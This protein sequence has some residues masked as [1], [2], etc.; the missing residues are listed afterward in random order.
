MDADAA[1]VAGYFDCIGIGE[2]V[3]SLLLAV[4][5]VPRGVSPIIRPNSDVPTELMQ[6]CALPQHVKH[7]LAYLRANVGEKVTL[8]DLATACSVPERTLLKQFKQFLGTSPLAHF[9]RIRLTT[10]RTELLRSDDTNSISEIASRCGFTHLGRFAADYRRTFGEKPSATRRRARQSSGTGAVTNHVSTLQYTSVDSRQRPSLVIQALRT[11]TLQE[12]RAAQELLEQ[13]AAA[14]SPIRLASVNFADPTS[15][16][17]LWPSQRR[18]KDASTRYHLSGRLAQCG[19]R[20][21]VTLWLIDAAGRHIWG[22]THDGPLDDVVNLRDRIVEAALC[23]VVPSITSAEIKRISGK[24]AENLVARELMMQ[25]FPLLLR[26]DVQSA[27]QAFVRASRAMQLDP[28]D[29]LPVALAAYCQARLSVCHGTASPTVA[30]DL[31]IQLARRAGSLDWGDPRVTTARAAVATLLEQ[32]DEAEVLAIRAL[33]MDPTS[34]WAWERRGFTRLH[35]WDAANPVRCDADR[36]IADFRRAMQFHGP[37]MPRENC[38]LGI[39]VAHCN[40]GHLEEAVRWVHRALAE[41]PRAAFLHRFLVFYTSRLGDRSAARQSGDELRRAHPEL[42]I[43][44]LTG[45]FPVDHTE[46][47]EFLADAGVPL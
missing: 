8:P 33:A 2:G 25:A 6:L 11:E 28:D 18:E 34:G 46:C 27:R 17:A 16:D 1:G 21:R 23:G 37:F 38:Y 39:A 30:R 44:S 13:V 45:V 36:A 47:L 5:N 40:A 7:A 43:S 42:T 29:A 9:Q 22:D 12:R 20:L 31:A 35:C 24:D 41:N 14:L 10:A 3:A 4:P 15:V 26:I 19:D 32:R